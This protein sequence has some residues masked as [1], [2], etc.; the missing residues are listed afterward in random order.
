[1]ADQI[2]EANDLA[3][4]HLDKSLA[5]HR[6]NAD[7]VPRLAG[8]ATPLAGADMAAREKV[9]AQAGLC[10]ACG[11]EIG[12]ARLAALPKTPYCI[13]CARESEGHRDQL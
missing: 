1:M 8:L 5:A 11:E 2:D 3:Q 4:R 10:R 6:Q 13:D 12:E 9:L 7:W